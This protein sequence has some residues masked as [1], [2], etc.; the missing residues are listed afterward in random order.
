MKTLKVLGA[1]LTYPSA[2]MVEA[3]PECLAIV[4]RERWIDNASQQHLRALA[5]WMAGQPLLDLQEEYVALFDRT[6]SLSLHLFE[7]VHGDSRDRGQALV[8]LTQIYQQKQLSIN[9]AETPDFLPMFLEYLSLVEAHESREMLGDAINVIAAV[10]AR[11][12]QRG[13]PYAAVFRSLEKAAA[14]APDSKAVEAALGEASGA[15]RTLDEIDAAWEE[16]FAFDNTT[17]DNG[18]PL[19]GAAADT[20]VRHASS[21]EGQQ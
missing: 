19:A 1:L 16:Q 8:D 15:E 10:G 21:G 4:E 14:T 20:G 7:H 6:P 3:L 17:A 18:C 13:S 5:D 2:E 12:K 11:L 9:T